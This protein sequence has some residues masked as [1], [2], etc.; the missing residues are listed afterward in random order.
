MIVEQIYISTFLMGLMGGT[1][2]AGMCGGI[3]SA[4]T[5]GIPEQKRK[6]NHTMTLY[7]L[8]YNSGRISSYIFAG[9]L[10]ASFDSV[11]EMVG[12][13]IIVRRIFTL[14]ADIDLDSRENICIVAR[15]PDGYPLPGWN[16]I[17]RVRTH[18]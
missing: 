12:N 7:L 10:V 15:L 13:G 9:V 8:L 4:L 1:H 16:P 3:V 17:N 6:D 18:N 11:F 2:C 14:V 5:L